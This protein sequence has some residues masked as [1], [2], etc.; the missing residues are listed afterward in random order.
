HQLPRRRTLGFLCLIVFL[1]L[2][3]IFRVLS[4]TNHRHTALVLWAI[5]FRT[6]R[7]W[8]DYNDF[9]G[10]THGPIVQYTASLSLHTGLHTTATATPKIATTRLKITTRIYQRRSIGVLLNF[11]SRG[12]LS[13]SAMRVCRGLTVSAEPF[14]L[15][16]A[17]GDIAASSMDGVPAGIDSRHA[18]RSSS[19]AIPLG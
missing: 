13:I 6:M 16:A 15:C 2:S 3:H 17:I 19:A 11:S 1:V 7:I 9:E 4:F 12:V 14:S 10:N 8:K 18:M 5:I